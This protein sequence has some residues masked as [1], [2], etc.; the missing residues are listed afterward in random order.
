MDITKALSTLRPGANWFLD[1]D[2]Y[3]GLTWLDEIQS[4]PT[5]DEIAQEIAR[6]KAE[7]FKNRYQRERQKEYPPIGEQL[8]MI[9][10]DIDA[11]KAAI[12]SIKEKY[13]KPE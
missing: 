11:W 8:D 4:K 1:G 10:H 9:Y 13:P 12:N 6:L 3:D 2:T 5:K 7:Y